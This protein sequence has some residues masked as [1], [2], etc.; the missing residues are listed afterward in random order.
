MRLILAAAIFAVSGLAAQAE[1]TQ[2]QFPSGAYSTT[3]ADTAWHATSNC[4]VLDVQAGQT[5]RIWVMD[6]DDVVFDVPGLG[7]GYRDVTFS[8]GSN[9]LD[10]YTMR[11]SNVEGGVPYR[12]AFDIR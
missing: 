3:V 8:L 2:V 9:Y 5:A 6:S 7:D 10:V 11:E 4:F 12:I 1:C